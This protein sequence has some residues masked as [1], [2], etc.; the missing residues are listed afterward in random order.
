MDSATHP[1]GCEDADTVAV[2]YLET[3]APEKCLGELCP[4]SSLCKTCRLFSMQPEQEAVALRRTWILLG[5][6][7]VVLGRKGSCLE[8][9]GRGRK[10]KG[11][12]LGE[13]GSAWKTRDGTWKNRDGA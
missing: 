3:T 6:T 13:E 9:K 7:R 8:E 11:E 2:G 1:T 12:C 4:L 5:R 10:K